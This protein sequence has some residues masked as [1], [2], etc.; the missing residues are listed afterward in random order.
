MRPAALLDGELG[1][2]VELEACGRRRRTLG[3][4]AT[5]GGGALARET[6]GERWEEAAQSVRLLFSDLGFAIKFAI[7][8]VTVTEEVEHTV[9][10]GLN[11][12]RTKPNPNIAD[13]QTDE[14]TTQTD[15]RTTKTLRPLLLGIDIDL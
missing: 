12:Q 15:V 9:G 2:G 6:V 8:L 14:P 3:V 7:D 4:R 10:P 1:A 13:L 11:R 5:G